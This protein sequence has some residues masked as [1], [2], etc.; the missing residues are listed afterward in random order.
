MHTK[1]TTITVHKRNISK[2][3]SIWALVVASILM[4]PL[5][6]KFPWT[7]SDYIFAGVV[8]F[9]SAAAYEFLTKNMRN[10]NYRIAVGVAV[11]LFVFF[12]WGL[13]V[14]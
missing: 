9:G 6:A 2:R 5:L 8:L 11:A 4:I 1:N 13:A 10:Q 7:G 3:L 14:A 12:I